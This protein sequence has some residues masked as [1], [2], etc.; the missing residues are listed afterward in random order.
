MENVLSESYAVPQSLLLS[1]EFSSLYKRLNKLPNTILTIDHGVVNVC[2]NNESN[3]TRVL[4]ELDEFSK[5]G[6]DHTESITICRPRGEYIWNALHY[7][8]SD[9][10]SFC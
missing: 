6:K 5:S 7:T 4:A 2:T 8:P 10:V 9:Q 3:F 1:E